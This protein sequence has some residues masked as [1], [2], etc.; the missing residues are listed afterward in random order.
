MTASVPTSNQ[1]LAE[2]MQ[3]VILT[4]VP[5]I[6][7]DIIKRDVPGIVRDIIQS[8]VPSIVRDIIQS[9]VPGMVHG[10]VREETASIKAEVSTQGILLRSIGSDVSSLKNQT[11]KLGIL[12]EDLEH[13]FDTVIELIEGNSNVRDQ[14]NDHETRITT[15]EAGQ[16]LLTRHS[17]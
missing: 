2:L 4:T 16:A 3:K 6:V 7:S 9:D 12:Y 14:V 1:D 5:G 13:R 8:D 11:R 17:Q 10:I 15:L